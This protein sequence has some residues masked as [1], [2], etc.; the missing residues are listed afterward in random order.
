MTDTTQNNPTLNQRYQIEKRGIRATRWLAAAAAALPLNQRRMLAQQIHSEIAAVAF[1]HNPDITATQIRGCL[2][3]T[4]WAYI[5]RSPNIGRRTMRVIEDFST[6]AAAQ[7]PTPSSILKDTLAH[8][9]A[10]EGTRRE[11]NNM[12]VLYTHRNVIDIIG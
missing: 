12:P 1:H 4:L 2:T 9:A 11:G 7:A 10:S 8:M 6:W 3:Q 5:Q